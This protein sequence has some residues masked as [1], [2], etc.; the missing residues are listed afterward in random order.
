MSDYF[1][2]WMK[3]LKLNW[4]TAQIKFMKTVGKTKVVDKV[5]LLIS[6]IVLA[7]TQFGCAY[8]S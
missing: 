6:I 2:F 8:W 4:G 3:G 7:A 1:M 5:L